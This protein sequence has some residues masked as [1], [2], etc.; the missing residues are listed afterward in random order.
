MNPK[1]IAFALSCLCLIAAEG[2]AQT[3]KGNFS[4][5]GSISFSSHKNEY[6]KGLSPYESKDV[7]LDI[8]P[9]IS[10]FI[11]NQLALGLITPYSYSRTTVGALKESNASYSFGPIARY[12]F[13]LGKEWAIFPEV[14]YSFGWIHTVSQ[15]YDFNSHVVGDI[16][17]YPIN[18][19]TKVFQCGG[20]L[21][22]FLNSNIGVEA[23]FYYQSV[24]DTYDHTDNLK[25]IRNDTNRSSFNYGLGVQAY[26]ARKK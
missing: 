6:T 18:G 7:N 13:L 26:F 22:Y 15:D 24:D 5:G 8:R 21:T 16:K 1:L 25:F 2:F 12:Y 23:K 3:T 20:G 19:K 4:L 14:S 17:D 9:S 11:A 10:Y